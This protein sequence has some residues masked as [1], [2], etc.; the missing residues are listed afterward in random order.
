MQKDNHKD[1]RYL[2]PGLELLKSKNSQDKN[3]KSYKFFDENR[4]EHVD[5]VKKYENCTRVI[6]DAEPKVGKREL[7]IIECLRQRISSNVDLNFIMITSLDR[8]DNKEQHKEMKEYGIEC[9]LAKQEKEFLS[10]IKKL[11]QSKNNMIFIF[12]DES[13]YGTNCRQT[14]NKLFKKLCETIDGLEKNN[15][16]KKIFLRYF[17]GSNEEILHSNYG[18]SCD[19]F[20]F[21]TP[22]FYRGAEWHLKNNLVHEADHFFVYDEDG[23]VI[24]SEQAISLLKEFTESDKPFSI[25]RVANKNL[26]IGPDFNYIKNNKK[27][28]DWL[29]LKFNIKFVAVDQNDSMNWG[30]QNS[31]SKNWSDYY[32]GPKKI[33]LINQ[34]CTRSTELG[35]IPLI[36][37]WH[38]FRSSQ[39]PYNTIIQSALRVSHY[40]YKTNELYWNTPEP[41]T[42]VHIY[43][44]V[45]C[46]KYR[47]GEISLEELRRK[48][49][50]ISS[51]IQSGTGC[52]NFRATPEMID[53]RTVEFLDIPQS[54]LNQI[55]HSKKIKQKYPA[56]NR[57]LSKHPK[58]IKHK[59]QYRLVTN[60]TTQKFLRTISANRKANIASCLIGKNHHV[61]LAPIF[62]DGPNEKYSKDFDQLI[63][64][65]GNVQN[66]I[67]LVTISEEEIQARKNRQKDKTLKAK[68]S[69]F[70]DGTISKL[71]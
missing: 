54:V 24:P 26:K 71:S 16:K 32:G 49:R 62:I 4:P 53:A 28:Q 21:P 13:D 50:K 68:N 48:K 42:G 31:S 55:K 10:H 18:K 14:M 60:D 35:F 58:V 27:I 1:L 30:W 7:K 3:T 41:H 65:Y 25:L 22:S 45:D 33:F 47:A 44:S 19:F 61:I 51:R 12:L 17:S 9:F 23:D 70:N 34:T 37:F 52:G 59:E 29:F 20:K 39:T 57:W 6:I 36:Y 56:I 15:C 67:A 2:I 38:D 63:K 46:I 66:K 69:M 8:K 40:P 11:Y 5:F 43:T 64:K